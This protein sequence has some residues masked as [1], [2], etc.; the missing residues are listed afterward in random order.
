[1]NKT[2]KKCLKTTKQFFFLKSMAVSLHG[3]SGTPN[4]GKEKQKEVVCSSL[5]P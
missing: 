4:S 5:P 3:R 2:K 1:M